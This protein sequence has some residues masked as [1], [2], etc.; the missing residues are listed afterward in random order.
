MT[1]RLTPQGATLNSVAPSFFETKSRSDAGEVRSI[2]IIP[3]DR[4]GGRC[5]FEA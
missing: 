1:W 5:L 3:A 4:I 2:R